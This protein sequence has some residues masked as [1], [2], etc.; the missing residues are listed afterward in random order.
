MWAIAADGT[1][2][3]GGLCNR[4]LAAFANEL[5]QLLQQVIGPAAKPG[6]QSDQQG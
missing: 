3:L 5:P 4:N 6:E 1:L 2:S